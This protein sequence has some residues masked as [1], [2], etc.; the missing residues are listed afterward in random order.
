[1]NKTNKEG[2]ELLHEFE[3]FRASSYLCPADKWTIGWG[4]TFYADGK[5]VKAGETITLAQGNRLF[6]VILKGFE[7]QVRKAVSTTL[8]DNQFSAL[9]SITYNV[10]V[11]GS[12]RSGILKLRNGQPSTLLKTINASPNNPV[13]TSLFEEWRSKGTKFENG[14]LRRRRAEAKLYFKT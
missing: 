7:S 3:S 1:M 8:N 12:S 14:L 13:I 2:I 10:G 6:E 5:P 4:N 9:V 11:G